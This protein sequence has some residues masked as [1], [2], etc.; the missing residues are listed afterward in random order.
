M[1]VLLRYLMLIGLAGIGSLAFL[2]SAA[3]I[4][5]TFVTAHAGEG[6]GQGEPLLW[7]M[8]IVG[9][10]GLAALVNFATTE[11]P[12][13]LKDWFRSAAMKVMPIAVVLFFAAIFV[14]V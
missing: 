2:G 9:V 13:M 6:L 7:V 12:G 3:I 8:A 11:F 4:A 10:L 5:E 1:G 14:F